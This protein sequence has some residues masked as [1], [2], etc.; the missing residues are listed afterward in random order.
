VI[1]RQSPAGKNCQTALLADSYSVFTNVVSKD[2]GLYAGIP[3]NRVPGERSSLGWKECLHI[4]I[5]QQVTVFA[6]AL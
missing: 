6:K 5:S 2:A 4:A 3:L 1:R